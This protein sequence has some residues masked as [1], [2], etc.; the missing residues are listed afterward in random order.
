MAAKAHGPIVG[1]HK[2]F[3]LVSCSYGLG[4]ALPAEQSELAKSLEVTYKRPMQK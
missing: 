2:N 1:L 4:S 3:P